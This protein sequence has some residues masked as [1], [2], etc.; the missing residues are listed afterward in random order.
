[1]GIGVIKVGTEGSRIFGLQL[2]V[3]SKM[4]SFACQYQHEK[5][6]IVISRIKENLGFCFVLFCF[7]RERV[8]ASEYVEMGRGREMAR[9]NTKQTPCSVQSPT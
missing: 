9:E 8:H 4:D 7:E 6:T 3:K 2:Q 5:R 1:M